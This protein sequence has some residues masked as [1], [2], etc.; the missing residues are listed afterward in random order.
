MSHFPPFA[1]LI[2]ARRLFPVSL[3]SKIIFVTIY[4]AFLP[5]PA[6]LHRKTAAVNFQI[7]CQFLTVIGNGEPAAS[8]CFRLDL[9][10]CQQFIPRRPFGCDLDLLVK[11][12]VFRRH[13][14]QKIE[15]Q[16]IVKRTG[17]GAGGHQTAAVKA[18]VL[19]FF[20]GHYADGKSIQSG[21][22]KRLSKKVQ[23]RIRTYENGGL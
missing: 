10:I 20:C 11:S 22:R 1:P 8:G 13:H 4:D 23:E 17:I 9:Q 5:Q 15:D 2:S 18:H 16:L 7:I 19:A 21:A 14:L 6:D 12:Q 3:Q